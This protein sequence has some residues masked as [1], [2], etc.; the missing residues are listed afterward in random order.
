MNSPCVFIV[1]VGRS[2]AS[3]LQSMLAMHPDLAFPPETVFLRRYVATG[4]L[5]KTV[6][7][8]G[9]EKAAQILERD[10]RFQRTGLDPREL[11]NALPQDQ[12]VTDGV[13]YRAWL[14]KIAERQNK[15]GSGDKD[16]RAIEYLGLLQQVFPN[17][18]V[19]HIIRDPRD[20]LASKKKA[21][22]SRKRGV[23][24]HIFANRVQLRV[25]RK[26]GMRLFKTRYHE[27]VYEEL[28]K[29]PEGELR[30]LSH[31]LG[32]HFDPAMLDFGN[33]AGRLVSEREMAWK[34]ETLG[35][36]LKNNQGKWQT[37]LTQWEVAL[38]ES[39]C[40]AQ[41]VVGKY[42]RSNA[43]RA[44]PF[45]SRVGV[46]IVAGV[47]VCLDPIYRLFRR[48]TIWQTRKCA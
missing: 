18:N 20:V 22:W 32:L 43:L 37:E 42:Q 10:E 15:P 41:F 14:R 27:I 47:I 8:E 17:C 31:E 16:P 12:E 45:C 23:M 35:P 48:Y 25:G 26:Q 9:I 38:T 46:L 3:L 29:D 5:T 30:N 40:N 7:R 13:V 21:E 39:V 1:G 33:S 4:L 24:R 28:L 2:G 11:M 6:K 34:K 19:V 44:L 36:L